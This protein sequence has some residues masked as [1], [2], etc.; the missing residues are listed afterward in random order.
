MS[1]ITN[2]NDI[3]LGL[4]VWVLH[5]DYDHQ[6]IKNYVS[7]TRL[8]K[9]I[10]HLVLPSR[11][12]VEDRTS[13]VEDFIASGLGRAIHDSIEKAWLHGYERSLSLLGYPESVI[14]RVLINPTD[15]QLLSVE[16]PLP[17]YLEQRAFREIEVNGVTYVVGGKFDMVAEGMVMDNKST[18]A[19]TWVYG[20]KDD[21]YQLQGSIYRWLNPKKITN[22]F[23]RINFIF[24]DWQKASASQN[25][26]YPPR[27][28][29]SK[30]IP[31]L[32]LDQT[33]QW[34][35]NKLSQVE[36]Y[37]NQDETSLP[38]CTDEELWRSE[39]VYKYYADPTK[40][41]GKSTKNFN[42]ASEANKFKAEKGHKGI[43][44][45]IAGTAKRCEYCDAASIC[46]QRKKM[47]N[48]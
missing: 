17:I 32:S 18:T 37:K 12:P 25:P 27:R 44:I 29:M 31:L 11:V 42:D 19:Y 15:E 48:D 16:N 6:D 13:D 40:T 28:L 33:E 34:I 10:R 39:P 43:V 26:K 22:D 2:A 47:S 23:I 3:P 7:A 5:D 35:R 21:D 4:A 1:S 20:G 45:T 36:R 9:P 8:M 38:Y 46:S 41:T 24:T 30:D 14:K